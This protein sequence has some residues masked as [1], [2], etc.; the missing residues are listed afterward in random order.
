MKK[1]RKQF[2]GI[3]LCIL[4]G[5][6]LTACADK[7][8]QQAEEESST[9]LYYWNTGEE[10]TISPEES[11]E[12][13][14]AVPA[15]EQSE[16]EEETSFVFEE[17]TTEEEEEEY[18][19][20][21]LFLAL[22]IGGNEKSMGF[23]WEA[24][25][26]DGEFIR[27]YEAENLEACRDFPGELQV[28]DDGKV[29]NYYTLAD[30]LEPGKK[31]GYQ[32][33]R[34][35]EW[36]KMYYFTTKKTSN[37]FNFLA[38]GDPQVGADETYQDILNWRQSVHKA[39]QLTEGASFLFTLGDQ[40]DSSGNKHEYDGFFDA[41]A[42]KT[43]PTAA[44]VGN[45]EVKND[46][47][48]KY[49][50]MPNLDAS[51]GITPAVG[52][53]SADYSFTCGDTLFLCLN[54]NNLNNA[55]HREFMENAIRT[56][57]T[58][59]GGKPRWI[60]AAMHH[61]VFS[62]TDHLENDVYLR[63]QEELS[64]AFSELN[65]DLVLMGHDHVYNRT[66][67]M[68]GNVPEII[69]DEKGQRPREAVSKDGKVIYFTLNSASGSKYYEQQQIGAEIAHNNQEEIPNITNVEV[70]EG[71]IV[72]TTYRTGDGSKVDEFILWH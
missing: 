70:T 7:D 4:L 65:V 58:V 17:E 44:L 24:T 15:E 35:D 50:I 42:M 27:L 3:V 66:F 38:A 5:V 40:V 56:Y 9:D 23:I 63:R 25:Y 14:Q 60:I 11:S 20:E 29:V 72:L 37:T 71:S 33:R 69:K 6:F 57:K 36:S 30:N 22:E 59:N 41:A 21:P 43:I 47:Y 53:K 12:E 2:I 26:N 54:T 8:K 10:V 55:G 13:S 19:I 31:Y 49:F 32:V 16:S 45:H 39:I 28:S 68:N 62:T 61:S 67:M 64:R 46:Y 51:R 52:G 1:W 48:G 18:A 34:N